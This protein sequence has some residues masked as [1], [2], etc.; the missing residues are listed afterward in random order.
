M[1]RRLKETH[2]RND[3]N[4]IGAV[5]SSLRNWST[6]TIIEERKV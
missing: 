2:A 1:I 3:G 5:D 4:E 6:A